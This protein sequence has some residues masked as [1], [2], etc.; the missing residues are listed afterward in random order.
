MYDFSSDIVYT[1]GQTRIAVN[2]IFQIN[3]LAQQ[4]IYVFLF[5]ALNR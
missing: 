3:A 4:F 1:L 5:F 2:I